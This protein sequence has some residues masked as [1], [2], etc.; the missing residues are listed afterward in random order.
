MTVACLLQNTVTAA[1]R[2]AGLRCRVFI[3][4][5][6]IILV[7]CCGCALCGMGRKQQV[8]VVQGGG[9]APQH[10]KN[11]AARQGSFQP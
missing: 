5:I 4:I 10:M 2:Q 7:C 3:H 11:P 6:L 9:Y 1:K 8:V